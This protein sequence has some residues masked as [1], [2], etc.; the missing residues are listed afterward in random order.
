MTKQA[1]RDLRV[2]GDSYIVGNAKTP[3]WARNIYIR[4]RDFLISFGNVEGVA[5]AATAQQQPPTQ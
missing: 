5:P 3:T 1:F 2:K 4:L